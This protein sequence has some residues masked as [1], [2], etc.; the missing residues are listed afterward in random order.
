MMPMAALRSHRPL[1]FDGLQLRRASGPWCWRRRALLLQLMGTVI[2]VGWIPGDWAKL[3]AMSVFWVIG[4]GW[5]SPAEITIAILVSLLFVAMD[6]AALH[7]GIFT[8]RHPEMSGLPV[9][10][11]C[12]WGFYILHVARFVGGRL[13][14]PSR[15]PLALGLALTFTTCFATITNPPILALVAGALLLMSLA[16]FHEP[17]DLASTVYMIAVG[18]VVEYVGVATGQWSYP[19]APPGGVPFW[20]VVMWGGV[21]LFSRRLLVPFLR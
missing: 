20:S 3:A 7:Q 5:L 13:G 11:Y 6:E 17:Q 12:M 19:H 14:H 15:M 4:F 9:Y 2:S 21:G 1:A 8:F 16:C 18:I 10:E